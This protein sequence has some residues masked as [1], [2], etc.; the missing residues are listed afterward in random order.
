MVSALDPRLSDLGSSPGEGHCIMFLDKT[1]Y[2]HSASLPPLSRW[3][4][5][6]E[7]LSFTVMNPL[8]LFKVMMAIYISMAT[9]SWTAKRNSLTQH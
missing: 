1:L 5:Q 4:I 2:S 9:H 6:A 7:T 8:T 3:G